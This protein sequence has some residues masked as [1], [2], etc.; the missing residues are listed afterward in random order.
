MVT[1]LPPDAQH[2]A[3]LQAAL[4][5]AFGALYLFVRH[6]VFPRHSAEFANRVVSL[7]HACVGLVGPFCV[8]DFSNL[9]VRALSVP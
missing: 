9:Q 5:A 6:A 2:E 7:M 3:Q 8:L 4:S 1:Q